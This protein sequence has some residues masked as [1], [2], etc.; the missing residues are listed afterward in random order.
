MTKIELANRNSPKQ[1][2]F[3][4]LAKQKLSNIVIFVYF[5]T[6]IPYNIGNS[7]P[8]TFF[9]YRRTIWIVRTVEHTINY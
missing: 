6:F 2:I 7:I 9:Y 8:G 4:D 1:L 5:S 3:R